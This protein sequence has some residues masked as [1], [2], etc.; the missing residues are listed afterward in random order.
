[1]HG[2]VHTQPKWEE[3]AEQIA[4]PQFIPIIYILLHCNSHSLCYWV[5]VARTLITG[6]VY[7]CCFSWTLSAQCVKKKYKKYISIK[8]GPVHVCACF[9]PTLVSDSQA[10]SER[11]NNDGIKSMSAGQLVKQRGLNFK[12]LRPRSENRA[13]ERGQRH[14]AQDN[15]A[16]ER[17][18]RR[19]RRSAEE[20]KGR[21]LWT[22][23]WIEGKLST[24]VYCDEMQPIFWFLN[25]QS[26]RSRASLAANGSL[27]RP[28]RN[29]ALRSLK[30][31][32]LSLNVW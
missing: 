6:T 1:M 9:T 12:T 23:E 5:H 27:N 2:S 31:H 20:R 18:R 30:S 22:T 15:E 28:D 21:R 24:L 25:Q 7:T 19:R 11:R 13:T 29:A 32:V 10:G 8:S 14:R 3:G 26:K 4:R 17:S 16:N